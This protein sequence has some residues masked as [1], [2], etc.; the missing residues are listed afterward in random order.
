MDF[1]EAWDFFVL[2]NK[3]I[4]EVTS[5]IICVH[6]NFIQFLYIKVFLSVGM[7]FKYAF[8]FY[9]KQLHKIALKLLFKMLHTKTYVVFQKN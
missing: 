5:L 4:L 3:H 2:I 7:R 9:I 8:F 1:K 6:Y